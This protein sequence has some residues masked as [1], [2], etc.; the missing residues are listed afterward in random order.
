[1][2]KWTVKILLMIAYCIPYT[3]W[4][5]RTDYEYWNADFHIVTIVS[6][7]LYCFI[8]VHWKS[9]FI[10][11]PGNIATYIASYYFISLDQSREWIYHFKPLSAFQFLNFFTVILIIIQLLIVYNLLV[12]ENY[13]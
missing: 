10:L 11:I 4:A 8:A 2:N 5:M 12:R 9:V 6:F 13:K 3:Y 7:V 1:M